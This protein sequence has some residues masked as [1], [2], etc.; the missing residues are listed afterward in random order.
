MLIEK[1]NATV[2]RPG[3]SCIFPYTEVATSITIR[4][5]KAQTVAPK[6]EGGMSKLHL[7]INDWIRIE[8]MLNNG[9]SFAEIGKAVGK[10]RS[11]IYGRFRTIASRETAVRSPT[12][13]FIRQG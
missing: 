2:G 7:T 6:G 3:R 11:T 10:D 4:I 5:P 13:Q 12:I 9:C 8:G 1:V